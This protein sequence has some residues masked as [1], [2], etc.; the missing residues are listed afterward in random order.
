MWVWRVKLKA[1]FRYSVLWVFHSRFDFHLNKFEFYSLIH[2]TTNHPPDVHPPSH[3]H[4]NKFEFYSLIHITTNHP[5]DV[6]PPSQCSAVLMFATKI[7]FTRSNDFG[8]PCRRKVKLLKQCSFSPGALVSSY[9]MDIVQILYKSFN[10][11]ST[12]LSI[13]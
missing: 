4:L 10:I 5:P 12:N 2:I 6:H 9:I 11:L 1:T 8:E 13:F 3:F 7:P